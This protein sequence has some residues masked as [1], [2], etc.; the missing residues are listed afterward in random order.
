MH[1]NIVKPNGFF[2]LLSLLL[3]KMA[4]ILSLGLDLVEYV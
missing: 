3:V 1:K 4:P 2:F